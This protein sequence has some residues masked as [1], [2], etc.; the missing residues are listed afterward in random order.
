MNKYVDF[1]INDGL[2]LCKV[3]DILIKVIKVSI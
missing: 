1:G 2:H 3:N